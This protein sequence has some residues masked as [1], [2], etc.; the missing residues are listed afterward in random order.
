MSFSSTPAA[1]SAPASKTAVPLAATFPDDEPIFASADASADTPVA[2]A[3]L[4]ERDD[5]RY[6]QAE[7][8]EAASASAAS[9]SVD[10]NREFRR[11]EVARAESSGSRNENLSKKKRR[12]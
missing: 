6:A 10:W 3:Q 12:W 11:P 7:R 2:E 9:T 5:S 4:R 1:G 8:T